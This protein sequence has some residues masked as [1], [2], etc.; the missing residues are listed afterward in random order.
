MLL[1]LSYVRR[2]EVG[3]VVVA[4]VVDSSRGWQRG[5]ER[6]RYNRHIEEV[7]TQTKGWLF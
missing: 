2:S 4:P 7:H 3:E 6:E 5:G 1:S